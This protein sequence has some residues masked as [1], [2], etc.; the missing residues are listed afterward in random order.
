[1][2]YVTYMDPHQFQSV[3][4]VSM[5][6]ERGNVFGIVIRKEKYKE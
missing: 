6:W 5:M 3:M 2:S 4:R 1:M